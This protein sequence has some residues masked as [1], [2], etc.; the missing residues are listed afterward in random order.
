MTTLRRNRRTAR[1]LHCGLGAL[2]ALLALALG[3]GAALAGERWSDLDGYKLSEVTLIGSHNTYDRENYRFLPD[4]LQHSQAIELDV[5]AQPGEYQFIVSHSDLVANHNNCYKPTSPD[6][7]TRDQDLKSC[8]EDLWIWHQRFPDHPLVIVK[9]EPKTGFLGNSTPEELD[10]QISSNSNPRIPRENIFRPADLLT[11][12]DGSRFATLDEAARANNWPTMAELRGKF[13]FEIVPGTA[14]EGLC[15]FL[16]D[17]NCQ[18]APKQYGARL[19]DG[20]IDSVIGFP[21]FFIFGQ[22]D[23][24]RGDWA[25]W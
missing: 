22:D 5:Y 14:Q 3:A 11:R 9:I 21:T 18:L 25:N 6:A 20:D 12:R 17:T 23:P 19:L 7:G 4:A 16:T 24:R 13:M 10:K 1:L 2:I 8:I 15:D